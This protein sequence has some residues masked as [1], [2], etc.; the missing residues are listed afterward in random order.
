ML[1]LLLS[2][3]VSVLCDGVRCVIDIATYNSIHTAAMNVSYVVTNE[4][5]LLL[6][7]EML[8]LL[9]VLVLLLL[10]LLPNTAA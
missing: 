4:A 6:L 5:Q 8:L 3:C 9:L 10:L 7:L 2:T 1:Q